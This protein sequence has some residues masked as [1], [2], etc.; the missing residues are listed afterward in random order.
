MAARLRVFVY[1]AIL[2]TSLGGG[3]ILGSG[4]AAAGGGHGA[5]GPAVAH[6]QGRSGQSH[7]GRGH[8]RTGASGDDANGTSAGTARGD[9]DSTVTTTSGTT[10]STTERDGEVSSHH[11]KAAPALPTST[12]CQIRGKV[13]FNPALKT[14]GTT[15]STMTVT[16]LLSRCTSGTTG[17]GHARAIENGH[18]TGLTGTV[19]QNDC[20]TF[21]SNTA[22]ALAGGAIAWTPKAKVASSTGITFP[23]G[24][25]STATA[26]GRSVIAVSYTGGSV[27]GGSFSNAGAT[28]L[29]VTSM[30]K[31]DQLSSRCASGL[32]NA[33][34]SGSIS[35]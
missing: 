29:T 17:H 26:G 4:P 22:P 33:A 25:G 9:D 16:G 5:H 24:T 32:H 15:A 6:D 23:V 19:P 14:G 13:S 27:A 8:G 10:T 20:A 7:H 31:V 30:Q 21:M 12:T 1:A 11:H 28:S 18:L 2:V 34:F 35:L 3:A